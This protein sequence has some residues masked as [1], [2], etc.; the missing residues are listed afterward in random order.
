M[1]VNSTKNMLTTNA[2]GI[3]VQ[4][5]PFTSMIIGGGPYQ[6]MGHLVQVAL[7]FHCLTPT[8]RVQC[9]FAPT[10]LLLFHTRLMLVD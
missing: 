5:T 1:L 6:R 3:C 4:Y 2:W 8:I 7:G 10:C 9:K